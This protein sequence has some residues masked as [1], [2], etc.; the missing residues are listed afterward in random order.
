MR[1]N[2]RSRYQAREN[3]IEEPIEDEDETDDRGTGQQSRDPYESVAGLEESRWETSPTRG[4]SKETSEEEGDGGPAGAGGVLGLLY[5]FQ[6]AQ[7]D[8]RPG[9]NI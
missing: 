8:G 7:T 3:I 6:K 9:V 5:Q 2:S 4:M 1:R